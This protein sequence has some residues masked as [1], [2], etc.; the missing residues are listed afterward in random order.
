MRPSLPRRLPRQLMKMALLRL[1][2]EQ[3]YL[4]DLS[5]LLSIDTAA[6]ACRCCGCFW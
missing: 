3:C 2:N 5:S 1:Q 6:C 4:L